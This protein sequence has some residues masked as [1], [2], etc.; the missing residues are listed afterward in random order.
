MALHSECHF[1][2]KMSLY[3][4]HNYCSFW[5]LFFCIYMVNACFLYIIDL[6]RNNCRE[7]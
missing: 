5:T 1:E 3:S 7:T 6:S 4:K 2:S